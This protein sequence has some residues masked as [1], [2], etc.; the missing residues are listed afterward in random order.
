MT[1]L[2]LPYIIDYENHAPV[3]RWKYASL[4]HDWIVDLGL[5]LE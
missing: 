1:L 4:A 2:W 5:V 3:A